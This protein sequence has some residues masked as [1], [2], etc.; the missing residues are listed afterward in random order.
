MGNGEGAAFIAF[1]FLVRIVEGLEKSLFLMRVVLVGLG[2]G[3]VCYAVVGHECL[4][5]GAPPG[6]D[7]ARLAALMFESADGGAVPLS[8]PVIDNGGDGAL[9]KRRC[10]RDA[11]FRKSGLPRIPVP[12]RMPAR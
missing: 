4:L 7:S 8:D 12:S 10:A 11:H 3:Q 2:L 1:A 5:K 9:A 6:R